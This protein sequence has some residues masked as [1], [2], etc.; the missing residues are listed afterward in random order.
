MR[1]LTE[2]GCRASASSSAADASAV[3][4]CTVSWMCAFARSSSSL[5]WRYL[6][7]SAWSSSILSAASGSLS[8]K[9]R[10]IASDASTVGVGEEASA[11]S[12]SSLA[13]SMCPSRS[14]MRPQPCAT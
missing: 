5:R 3:R 12:Y 9:A 1:T 7:S 14:S 13:R 11:L 4:S 2:P 10:S 6:G 8:W